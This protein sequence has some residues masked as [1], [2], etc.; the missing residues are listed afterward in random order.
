MKFQILK[1]IPVI[2]VK[3]SNKG[4]VALFTVLIASVVLAMALGISN[5]S[6][7]QIIL[8][9]SVTDATK[10]FY[11]ADS[12]IECALY[13]DL[14]VSPN[15]FSATSAPINCG[16]NINIE[17]QELL[18]SVFSFSID[19]NNGSGTSCANVTVDKTDIL[20]VTTVISKGTNTPC[21]TISPR[22]V[23]RAIQITY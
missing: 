11:A 15:P 2:R 7:K 21:N 18:T 1:K 8:S 4:F 19:F 14:R 9:G 20:G 12:G 16:G 5:I 3:N 17:V 13:Y 22:Q 10:A 6:L 23:E